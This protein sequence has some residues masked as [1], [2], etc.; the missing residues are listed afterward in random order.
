MI[1][2]SIESPFIH[3]GQLADDR[4]RRYECWGLVLLMHGDRCSRDAEFLG[5]DESGELTRSIRQRVP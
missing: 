3:T 4:R 5:H 1:A 2:Q